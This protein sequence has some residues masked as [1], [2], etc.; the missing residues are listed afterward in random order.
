[1]CTRGRPFAGSP[2]CVNVREHRW[3]LGGPSSRPCSP[4]T[5]TRACGTRAPAA[6]SSAR[7]QHG[8]LRARCISIA[9]RERGEDHG[10][11]PILKSQVFGVP[12]IK[13]YNTRYGAKDTKQG[14][15]SYC[16][17]A[18]ARGWGSGKGDPAHLFPRHRWFTYSWM[19]IALF[20]SLYGDGDPAPAN[21]VTELMAVLINLGFKFTDN[22]D[23]RPS[24][25]HRL[26][27]AST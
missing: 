26:P 4:A 23:V 5:T 25:A 21:S 22:I 16:V 20:I 13:K 18:K 3:G 7:R 8:A 1:M 24:L 17:N 14:E 12:W 19:N 15:Y 10:M 27:T 6:S 2:A 11:S 9:R